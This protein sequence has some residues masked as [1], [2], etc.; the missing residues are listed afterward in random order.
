MLMNGKSCL[1]PILIS[2]K[3]I[4]PLQGLSKHILETNFAEIKAAPF[5]QSNFH[6]IQESS[7]GCLD[8]EL[9]I[10][11]SQIKIKWS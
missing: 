10:N 3:I 8:A 5:V 6:W 4:K 9:Y 1:I 11:N 2:S 7:S